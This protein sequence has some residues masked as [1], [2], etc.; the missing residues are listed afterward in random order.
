MTHRLQRLA[1]AAIAA[2]MVATATAAPPAAAPARPQLSSSDRYFLADVLS[3]NQLEIDVSTYAAKH[4][5]S[6]SVRQF[7]KDMLAEHHKIASEMQKANDGVV[8]PPLPSP[9][10]GPNLEGRTGVEFDKA[11]VGLMVTY[12]DAALGRF[13]NADGPQH[14]APIRDMAKIVLPMISQNDAT[15]KAMKRSLDGKK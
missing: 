15:A 8:V 7:A 2:A 13:R 3:A 11:Y 6:D 12:D 14:G 5:S 9:Q 4:A 1:I 10:P